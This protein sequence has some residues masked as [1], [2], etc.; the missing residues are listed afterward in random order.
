MDEL[1]K[2]MELFL[3]RTSPFRQGI[4]VL[5]EYDRKWLL[6]VI[7]TPKKETNESTRKYLVFGKQ[8]HEQLLVF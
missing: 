7:K 8:D 6:Q 2:K 4:R 1:L 3:N 5:S